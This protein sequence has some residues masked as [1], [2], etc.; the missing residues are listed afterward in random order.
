MGGA[1]ERMIGMIRRLMAAILPRT[2]R[3]TDEILETLFCEVESMIISRP[4]TK[5]SDDPNDLSPLTPNHLLIMSSVITIHPGNFDQGDMYRKRWRHVQ[6]L[7]NQLWRKWLRV[8][9]PELQ[10]RS[11]W[12]KPQINFQRADFVLI[13]DELNLRYLWPLGLV[14]EVNQGRDGLVRSV[15]VKTHATELVRPITKVVLLEA[16]LPESNI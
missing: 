3:L 8:Y 13:L 7:A 14:K 4:L 9:L 5:L 6:H 10:K 16:S 15:K 1:W 2:V 11:K 12:S